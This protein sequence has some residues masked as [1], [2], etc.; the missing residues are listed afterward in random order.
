MDS[1]D[2]RYE[3]LR[4]K[5]RRNKKYYETISEISKPDKKPGQRGEAVR[6][7]C[8]SPYFA[9]NFDKIIKRE[10]E[11]KNGL[12]F[13]TVDAIA[14]KENCINFIEFKDASLSDKEKLRTYLKIDESHRYFEKVLLKSKFLDT[15]S[16]KTRFIFVYNPEKVGNGSKGYQ[17][18]D[19]EFHGWGSKEK[20]VKGSSIKSKLRR[21]LVVC[22]WLEYFDEIEFLEAEEFVR[23]VALYCNEN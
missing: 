2:K 9:Y 19:D 22:E 15:L 11:K 5:F 10:A 12:A 4:K 23:N 18:I 6:P 17:R 7:L 1:F 8:D 13:C 21:I 14:F 3:K 20:V 16:V